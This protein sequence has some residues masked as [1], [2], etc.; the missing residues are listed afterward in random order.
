MK[1][2]IDEPFDDVDYAYHLYM[3]FGENRETEE[4]IKQLFYKI[5][6]L[7]KRHMKLT[8]KD[9]P[10]KFVVPCTIAGHFY[11]NALCDT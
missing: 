7:Q 1:I 3:F 9:D 10:G 2:P 11:Q 4:D 8:K 5:R 6:A